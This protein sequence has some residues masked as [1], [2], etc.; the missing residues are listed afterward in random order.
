MALTSQELS[1]FRLKISLT[2]EQI[3]T[4]NSIPIDI[5]LPQSGVGFYYRVTQFDCRINFGTVAFTSTILFL[6]SSSFSGGAGQYGN[7]AVAESGNQILRGVP[8]GTIID[9][10]CSENDTL[11]ISSDADSVVGD[12]TI[13]CYINIEKVA[14]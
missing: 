11:S 10:E 14:I 1:A 6:G 2:S 13:D 7:D 9:R 4:A 3:K 12:S 5:G 8:Q